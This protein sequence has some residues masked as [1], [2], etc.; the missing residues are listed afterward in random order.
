VLIVNLLLLL[1]TKDYKIYIAA[2]NFALVVHTCFTDV[3]LV[4][5]TVTE[6]SDTVRQSGLQNPKRFGGWIFPFAPEDGSKGRLGNVDFFRLIRRETS[7]VAVWTVNTFHRQNPSK[8]Y[9]FL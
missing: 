8:L 4:T 1:V 7:T 9:E 2:S 6:I 3:L 5:I